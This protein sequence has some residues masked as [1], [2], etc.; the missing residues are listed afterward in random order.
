M[1]R[2]FPV[3]IS[4]DTLMPEGNVSSTPS[5]LN[6]RLVNRIRA[7]NTKPL[8]SSTSA[9]GERSRTMSASATSPKVVCPYKTLG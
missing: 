7:G 4:A 3:T 2:R 5:T 9:L 1:T 8:F 6:W